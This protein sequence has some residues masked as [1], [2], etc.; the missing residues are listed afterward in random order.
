M[1]ARRVIT[2]NRMVLTTHGELDVQAAEGE[3]LARLFIGTSGWMYEHWKGVFYPEDLRSE[4][5]FAYFAERLNSVEIN[6]SFYRLPPRETFES[7]ASQAPEGFRYAVKASRYITH[8]KKLRDPASGVEHFYGNLAG[9]ADRCAVV[10]FQ[11][12][13]RWKVNTARL[14]AFLDL[15]PEVYRCAFE[16]RDESWL[17]AE[18]YGLLRERNIALVAADRPFYPAPRQR[19]ADF[20]YFRMHG[21]HGRSAPDYTPREIAGLAAEAAGELD[22]GRDVFVYFNNDYRGHAVADAMMLRERVLEKRRV[23]A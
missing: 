1:A 21:G 6:N 16:F 2:R 4:D 23:D 7:W 13:P 18:V 12:P 5:W 19:T 8:V 22:E 10:L 14:A 17:N 9:M 11:L 15:V 3:T 20:T